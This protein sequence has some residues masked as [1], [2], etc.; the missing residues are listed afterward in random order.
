MMC[1]CSGWRVTTPQG[2]SKVGLSH[3]KLS[4]PVSQDP[5]HLGCPCTPDP[6]GFRVLACPWWSME[7][8]QAGREEAAEGSGLMGPAALGRP[9]PSLGQSGW[10]GPA[11]VPED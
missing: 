8:L 7:G 4:P 11:G 3:S 1:F 9:A 6:H 10:R 5:C 2:R